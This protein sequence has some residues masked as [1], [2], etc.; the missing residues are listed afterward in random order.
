MS[1][2]IRRS[3]IPVDLDSVWEFHSTVDGLQ[4][5][6]P[7]MANLRVEELSIPDDGTVL[8]EGSEMVLSARPIPGGPRTRLRTK[9]VKR[10][11]TPSEAVFVD[12]LQT[13]PL[14]TWRHTHRFV[15]SG[16]STELID[17][18]EFE[19]GYGRVVDAG[20]KLGLRLA[21]ADRHRRTREI[22]DG[23]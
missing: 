23:K 17:D 14:E 11:Q 9:I 5:L 7:A 2:F 13:G 1:R 21:F 18:I 12:E 20:F 4:A 3:R 22:F 19:T 10:E 8:I 6:T 15:A 16:E